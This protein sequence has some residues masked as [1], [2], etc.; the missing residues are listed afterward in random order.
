[1]V[2]KYRNTI[3]NPYGD[4]SAASASGPLQTAL[5]ELTRR[6]AFYLFHPGYCAASLPIEY[7][8]EKVVK[9]K[10]DVAAILKFFSFFSPNRIRHHDAAPV[11]PIGGMRKGGFS[12]AL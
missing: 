1:M 4:A 3:Q 2:R 8:Y 7:F 11:A 9:V 12:G 10:A 6:S 5:S